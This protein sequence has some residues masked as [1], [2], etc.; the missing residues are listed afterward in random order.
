M[1][2]F[3]C[4]SNTGLYYPYIDLYISLNCLLSI[5]F[6]HNLFIDKSVV[7]PYHWLRLF[8][9]SP[10]ICYKLNKPIS[11]TIYNFNELVPDLDVKI[12][13]SYENANTLNSV[14]QQLV[15]FLQSI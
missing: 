10:V 13:D 8:T 2:F 11:N 9:E 4:S 6:L 14:I 1:P 3:M 12:P 15:M 7:L 5:S